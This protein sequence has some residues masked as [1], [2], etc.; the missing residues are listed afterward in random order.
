ML[1]HRQAELHRFIFDYMREVGWCPS[2]DEM[3]EA[4][5]VNSRSSIQRLVWSLEE[6]GYITRIPH[7][8]RSIKLLKNPPLHN[9]AYLKAVQPPGEDQKL[10]RVYP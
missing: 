2:Y 8:Y 7:L 5:G 6:R 3:S 9:T 1:T 4:L 10:I